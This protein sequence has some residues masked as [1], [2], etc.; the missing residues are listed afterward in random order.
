MVPYFLCLLP[1][2]FFLQFRK[3]CPLKINSDVIGKITTGA[4]MVNALLLIW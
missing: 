1:P 2:N 4:K 3:K